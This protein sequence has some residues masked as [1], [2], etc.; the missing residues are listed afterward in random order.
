MPLPRRSRFVTTSQD[1]TPT[2]PAQ[3]F[4]PESGGG[5]GSRHISA[6]GIPASYQVR[7]DKLAHIV[8]RLL[9]D[10]WPDFDDLINFGQSSQ[11]FLWY[12]DAAEASSFLVYL[13]SPAAGQSIKPVPDGQYPRV[14]QVTI[15]VRGVGS[16]EPWLAYFDG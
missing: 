13:E 14:W 6:A 11:S 5:V 15:T 12:P 10:E 3:S 7:R 2:W 16:V 4:L 9:E 8:L 1:F